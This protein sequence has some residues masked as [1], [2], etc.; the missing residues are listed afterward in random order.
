MTQGKKAGAGPSLSDFQRTTAEYAFRRLYGDSD[1]TRRFLVA[2]ETGLGKTH[3]AREVIAQTIEHLQHADHVSRIDIVYVCSNADIAAQNIRKLNITG[4]E[5]PSFATRLSLLI[6][7]PEM[8]KA[9]ADGGSKPTTFVAFTPG[10]SFQLGHQMGRKEERAVLYVLLRD[11]LGLRGA[12]ATAALRIFQ[13]GVSTWQKFRDWNVGAVDTDNLEPEIRQTFLKEFDQSQE[14]ASLVSLIDE[15]AGRSA[16]SDSQQLA[17]RII[18]G[19]LRRMLSRSALQA[20]E[21]DLVILDEFQRFRDL[22]DV[23]TGGDAAEL[24]DDLFNHPDA[25]VLLLSATP[26]KPFTYAEEAGPDGGH[27]ADFLKTLDFLAASDVAVDSVRTDLDELRQAALAGEPTV[28]I[29]DR[30]QSQLRKWIARTERPSGANRAITVHGNT[31]QLR[32][33]AEDFNGFVALRNVADAVKAPLTVE[34]WKSSPYFL[35]FLRGYRVGEHLREDMKDPDRRAELMPLFRGA[36]RIDK[37]RVENF[38]EVEW[39][40]ARMRALAAETLDQGWWKLLWMPPSLPYHAL[41]GPYASIYPTTITKSLIFSSWVAA[42][43]A[44]ASLLSYEVERQI[45]TQAGHTVN[46]AADRAS[47]SSRLDY[48]APNGRAS[49]MSALALFWPHP[50]LAVLTD[51]LD[52]ARQHRDDPDLPGVDRLIEWA[53]GQAANLVGPNGDN[54]STTSAPWY[55]F[56]SVLGERNST[57]ASELAAVPRSAVVDALAGIS[58]GRDADRD[59]SALDAHVGQMLSALDD[60]APDVERPA[61]LR[62]TTALLGLGAPGNIAWR[63]LNRLRRA[64]DQ[65]TEIGRWRAAAILASGLRSLFVRPEAVLLLDGIYGGSGGDAED[66]GAYWR[67]V[68]QYCI[69]GGLQAALD[70]YIHHLAGDSGSNPT[71]DEGLISLAL[72]A[73]RAITLRESVY[74]ATDID[75]FD[76][77]G[78]AFP[79]RY[80]LRFGSTQRS[81]EEARLPEVRAAFNSPFWPFVLAT[82]SIGQEG[83]DFHWW[84]HSI[85]HWNL[86]G[87]PVDFEQREG[88]V[89]RYKGHAIRKNVATAHRSEALAT[90]I[91]DPWGAAFEAATANDAHDSDGLSPFWIYP[92]DARIQRRIMTLPLSRDQDRWDQLQESLALYRLAFGQPRQEDMLAA[93]QRRGIASQPDQIPPTLL[94]S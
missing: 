24:A 92:G 64:D 62:E 69:D 91:T 74:R 67:K 72:T 48:R 80:A 54:R 56:A 9:A 86:P 70:E 73:R 59:R 25:H 33:R 84:C 18:V 7:M 53:Q 28:D 1:S 35:N 85:V 13:G 82:T 43:S 31:D 6:T 14:R 41:A 77:Q 42:P 12:R 71:T 79:S 88:R 76:D 40:N 75:H 15:V 51:P 26:Y 37:S 2:D 61:D 63:A 66:I 44:I 4:S 23:K 29:R 36:Q 65:V 46:T 52:A 3:V 38:Q 16:L 94:A 87:N 93:L 45:F 5:S 19:E 83:V 89:D 68:A 47:I 17:A 20:L 11:H 49:S 81:H 57:L 55:W 21:P 30:V 34:Y 32:V 22:L 27:Y 50:T 39:G 10:T 90:G 60:W 78:I 8:L 58:E